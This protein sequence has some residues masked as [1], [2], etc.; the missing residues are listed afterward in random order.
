MSE[1]SRLKNEQAEIVEA[2][3]R[4]VQAEMDTAAELRRQNDLAAKTLAELER[5]RQGQQQRVKLAFDT[6]DKVT[7]LLAALPKAFRDIKQINKRLAELERRHER[8][9]DILLLLLT[10]RSQRKIGEAVEDLEAEIAER[11]ATQRKLLRQHKRNLAKLNERAAAYGALSVPLELRNE[12]EA[13]EETI[14]EIEG[15]RKGGR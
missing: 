8:T 13:E 3:H 7:G 11:D 9:D 5:T 12:I 6:N 15:R 1:S 14:V 10:E 2:I 4:Q